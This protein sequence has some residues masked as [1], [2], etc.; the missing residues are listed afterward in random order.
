MFNKKYF[1]FPFA[2]TAIYFITSDCS[3]WQ[4]G[5]LSFKERKETKKAMPTQWHQYKQAQKEIRG[6]K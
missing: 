1:L 3:Q 2:F 4:K 6:F 5:T